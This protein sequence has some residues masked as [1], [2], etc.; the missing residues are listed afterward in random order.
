MSA[1]R[2]EV[3]TGELAGRSY[4]MEERRFVIGR[5]PRCHIVIPK[6]YISREH[7]RIVR[8]GEDFVIDGLSET[9]PVLM[10]RRPIREHLLNDGDV[11]EVCGIR[12]R[13]CGASAAA[14]GN[15]RTSAHG[16]QARDSGP[17]PVAG[18]PT[19]LRDS[20][21][22]GDSEALRGAAA[23][24]D[25]SW[26]DE[27]AFVPSAPAPGPGKGRGASQA[28]DPADDSW[29]NE[30]SFTPAGL[31]SEP[32]DPGPASTS[33][34]VVFEVDDEDDSGEKTGELPVQQLS[35]LSA[36]G[37]GVIGEE[38]SSERTAEL[39]KVVDPDDPNYDPFA[40]V[41]DPKA[42]VKQED[43]Q[44]EKT[45]R[46]LSIVGF[47]GIVVA[48]FVYQSL[49]KTKPPSIQPVA[50]PI[51]VALGQTL[52]FEEAW[53]ADDPPITRASTRPN[54]RPQPEDLLL[55]EPAEVEWI[56]P[57]IRRRTILLI[58]GAREGEG[59]FQLQFRTSNRIKVWTV[60]VEGANPHDVGRDARRE[61]L[62]KLPARDLRHEIEKHLASGETY[63]RERDSP[64]KEGFYRQAADEFG[65]AVDA[66]LALS[67]QLAAQGRSNKDVLELVRRCEDL[68]TKAQE[69]HEAFQQREEGRYEAMVSRGNESMDAIVDQL[70]RVLRI[71]NHTC[72]VKHKRLSILLR[73]NYGI[74]AHGIDRCELDAD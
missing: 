28:A 60:Q 38:S 73:E 10:D 61:Q 59:T 71:I 16:R 67:A 11:F 56:V 19:D 17:L 42:K 72:D 44:R 64:G 33:G 55:D 18:V 9:N 48:F 52:V 53:P 63:R 21:R 24:D 31:V 29:A 27:A 51:T 4:T 40:Q 57:H 58:R 23:P 36:R 22:D 70:K 65:R 68:E 62:K 49:N 69:D 1:P 15:G 13:F 26:Q 50:T 32:P 47:I 34:R 3:L 46:L 54:G 74:P 14:R 41:E 37:S 43:P 6:K 5:A 66:A 8:E 20:W 12:F 2:V 25:D 7:A 45:L 30:E 35:T 39:G